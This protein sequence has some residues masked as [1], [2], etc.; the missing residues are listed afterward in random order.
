MANEKMISEDELL[1]ALNDLEG[2]VPDEE[3]NDEEVEKAE[4]EDS[5]EDESEEDS[6]ESG[7]ED[8]EESAKSHGHKA[9]KSH[10]ADSPGMPS[11]TREAD[12]GF[13]A[14]SGASEDPEHFETNADEYDPT[15][16]SMKSLVNDNDTL[17]KG[18]EVSAFLEA[19]TDATTESVDRLAKSQ[20]DFQNEQRE[21]NVKVQKAL[22]AIGNM[23]LG[24]K[25]SQAEYE[26]APVSP[27]PRA[28][29]SKSEVAERFA[30]V[31]DNDAPRY[32]KAQT[33]D[34]LTDLAVKGDVPSLV[35]SA[36]ESSG[37][38]DPSYVGLVNNKLKTMFG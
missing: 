33:L 12:G 18:F 29:L 8:D 21:F 26:E 31:A 30:A 17:R 38:V 5:S 11:N 34:A 22:V 13:A 14:E 10:T 2:V 3:D 27:R 23:M 19:L 28:V 7:G 20:A 25:K 32:T 24:V 4:D 9:R 37:F 35:V 1:K 15:G 6:D 16:A 36:Y